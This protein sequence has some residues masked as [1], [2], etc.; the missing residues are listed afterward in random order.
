M[1][2]E[3]D[4]VLDIDMLAASLRADA[5]DLHAFVEALAVKLEEALP[6]GVRVER[7]RSGLRGPRTVRAISV[8]T[9]G[10]RLQLRAE[11]GALQMLCARTSGG[12]V[13]KNE[14]VDT[15]EWLRRLSV[16]LAAQAGR[17]QIT[18]QALE[19]LL[20]G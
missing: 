12:I 5:T 14:T 4:P 15:D 16:A 3:N 1:L 9:E 20:N 13:L 17:S 18:R 2:E 19:R 10:E 11:N 8:D 6:G 7:R